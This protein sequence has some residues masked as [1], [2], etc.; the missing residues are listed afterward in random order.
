MTNKQE[1]LWG[2]FL[3][4]GICLLSLYFVS[5]VTSDLRASLKTA[6]AE[7][8]YLKDCWDAENQQNLS[9]DTCVESPFWEE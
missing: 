8:R 5:F 6:N 1:W 7:I 2:F 4:I 9:T 3:G